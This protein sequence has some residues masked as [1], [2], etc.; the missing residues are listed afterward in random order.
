[1]EAYARSYVEL[2]VSFATATAAG[3]AGIGPR[4]FISDADSGVLE[5]HR[6]LK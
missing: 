6:V 2:A 5:T 1:M 4:I 3:D